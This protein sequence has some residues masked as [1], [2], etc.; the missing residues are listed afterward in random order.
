M[1]HICVSKLTIIGSDNDMS[2]GRHQA[3]ICTNDGILFIGAVGTTFIE[4]W[5]KIHAF[6]FTK[7]HLKISSGKWRSFILDLNV[8]THFK[9]VI[10]C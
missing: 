7:I 9:T 4:I 2:P 6:S 10:R 8:L 3:I 5:I 1:A